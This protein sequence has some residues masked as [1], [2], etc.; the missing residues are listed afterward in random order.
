MN[1]KVSGEE[2]RD[3]EKSRIEKELIRLKKQAE[4]KRERLKNKLKWLDKE[5]RAAFFY[6]FYLALYFEKMRG[7][8]IGQKVEHDINPLSAKALGTEMIAM[9]ISHPRD[10]RP[11]IGG[12]TTNTDLDYLQK[13]ESKTTEA[14]EK[15]SLLLSHSDG[16]E[17]P[18]IGLDELLKKFDISTLKN[19][20][21]N[22]VFFPSFVSDFAGVEDILE[23]ITETLLNPQIDDPVALMKKI[24][25]TW[26]SVYS[27]FPKAFSWMDIK[28]EDQCIWVWDTLK[29]KGVS[30]PLN[31]LNNYQRWYFICATFDF[32]NGW[33]S[34]QLEELKNKRKKAN[35]HFLELKASSQAPQK[36]KKVLMTEL[37]K[38]WLQQVRRTKSVST[39]DLTT[40]PAK[41]KK[42]M[43]KLSGGYGISEMEMLVTLIDNEY[44]AI[45]KGDRN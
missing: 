27:D 31:P 18:E 6:F 32:W 15:N 25:K 30:P 7:Q 39:V 17:K 38:A 40:L 24:N 45:I 20:P 16:Y 29:E 35:Q 1:K 22:G 37:E 21:A 42:K 28:N 5:P 23:Y 12:M 9:E 19:K 26:S 33:T 44:I 14:D 11:M 10:D 41:S 43:A 34:E 36:H 3:W 2:S 8:L 4:E 13:S